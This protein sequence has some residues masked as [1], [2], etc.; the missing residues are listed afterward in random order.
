MDFINTLPHGEDACFLA[1]HLELHCDVEHGVTDE[2]LAAIF[3]ACS[4]LEFLYL[5]GAP[6]L[7]DRTL[8][9]LATAAPYLSYLDVSGCTLLTDVGILELAATAT[10][11]VV[12][13]L[14]AI[15][16]LADPAISALACSL[17][18]LLELE[19]CDLPLITAASVRD[20]WTFSRN[21]QR[22]KLA[23]CTQLTDRAFPFAPRPRSQGSGEL[24]GEDGVAPPARPPTWL[25][26]LPPLILSHDANAFLDLRL[27][28][29]A[30]CPKIT[31]AAI[32]GI[33]T[34]AHYIQHLTVS[35]CVLLTDGALE[36]IAVLGAYLGVLRLAQL[37][38]ITDRGI[39]HLVRSC[40]QLKSVDV[41]LC[42]NLTDL[43]V[44]ELAGLPLR[45]LVIAGIPRVTDNALLFIAEHTPAL[46]RLH[47][48][49][50]ARLSLD[51]AHVVV[52]KLVRLAVFGASGVRA[53][54][55]A[56]VARFSDPAP[57]GYDERA[58]GVYR[59]FRGENV[60]ALC[61]FLDKELERRRDAERRNIIFVPREDDSTAL[62]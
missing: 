34:H 1:Q 32:A 29:L 51:A 25:D 12:L 14:S 3:P 7:S 47:I 58:R 53:L 50:C 33:V 27:L 19:L 54:R 28:D 37:E 20:I 2:E 55:R 46:E 61:V 56:G 11:L 57:P 48:A 21:L 45:R 5:S 36:S 52:R 44:L 43:A 16:G 39:V 6:D 42:T 13:K 62:Y 24:E 40:P 10:N 41:S 59:V 49:H 38:R 30:H 31:D 4:H 35:G 26:E 22:L 18:H 23:R 15:P 17:P 60:R 8:I 9:L